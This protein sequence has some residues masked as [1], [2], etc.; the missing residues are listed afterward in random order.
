M[1]SVAGVGG[2]DVFDLLSPLKVGLC[3]YQMDPTQDAGGTAVG[4][5]DLMITDCHYC[6]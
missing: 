5:S 2:S 6:Q 1:D 4:K 3:L